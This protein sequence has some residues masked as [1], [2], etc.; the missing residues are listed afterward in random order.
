MLFTDR[1]V[2]IKKNFAQGLECTGRG[3]GK[4]FLDTDRARPVNNIFFFS[5]TYFKVVSG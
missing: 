3:Q 1:E 4:V 2:R 5:E